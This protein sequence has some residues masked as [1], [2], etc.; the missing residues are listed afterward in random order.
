MTGKVALFEIQGETFALDIAGIVQ[1]FETPQ[2]FFL[3]LLPAGFAGVLLYRDTIVPCLDAT[4]LLGDSG[5]G[6]SAAYTIVYAA[7]PG[8]AALAVDHLG[9]VVDVGRGRFEAAEKNNG[10]Y[11]NRVFVF[12]ERRYPL[13][14]VDK[15]I[16]SLSAEN[17]PAP[18][19]MGQG[20]LDE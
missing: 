4:P 13:L 12:A 11:F 3:P 6:T 5:V 15:W 9:A 16:A 14:D 18:P 2:V 17:F 7:D 20:G 8:L 19:T 1:I 10:S